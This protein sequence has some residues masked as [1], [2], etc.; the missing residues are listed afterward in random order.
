MNIKTYNSI[1][2]KIKFIKIENGAGFIFN[3]Q[4]YQCNLDN[5]KELKSILEPPYKVSFCGLSRANIGRILGDLKNDDNEI[6]CYR[7]KNPRNNLLTY[8]AIIT[9][10][11]KVLKK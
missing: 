4:L 11:T 2:S 1:Q 7:V 3:N 6:F 5:L 10:K 8:Y 9:L